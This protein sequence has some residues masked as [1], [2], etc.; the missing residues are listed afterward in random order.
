M[1][2]DFWHER[3]ENGQIGFH[4]SEYNPYL[5]KHWPEMNIEPG[6]K[7]FVPLAGKSNDMFW[8]AGQ[9]YKVMGVELS[10]IAVKA[11]FAENQLD[12]EISNQDTFDI[13]RSPNID[14]YCGD[15]FQLSKN[16]LE[17]TQAVFDRASLIALPP[18]LRKQYV[19][20]LHDILPTD[21]KILLISMEY[22]QQQM[23]GPPFS[24]HEEEVFELYQDGFNVSRL[25]CFDVLAHNERFKERGL[26]GMHECIYR[27]KKKE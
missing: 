20:K 4:Q 7:V 10:S 14:L 22:P 23:D 6:S 13:Y 24:V 21:A 11:F 1:E 18:S 17:G 5:L 8:L 26:T 12:Y 27:I 25:E 9:G 16:M 15:F 3:W 2:L 19:A